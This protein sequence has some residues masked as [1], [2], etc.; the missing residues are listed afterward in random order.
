MIKH[1]IHMDQNTDEQNLGAG[2]PVMKTNVGVDLKLKDALTAEI[3]QHV[4]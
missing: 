3:P 4:I 1:T 2:L